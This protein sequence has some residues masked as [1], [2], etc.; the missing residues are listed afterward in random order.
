MSVNLGDTTTEG[1]ENGLSPAQMHVCGPYTAADNGSIDSISVDLHGSNGSP[2]GSVAYRLVV[3]E[4]IAGVVS[5]LVAQTADHTL[6]QDDNGTVTWAPKALA[7]LVSGHFYAIGVE[8]GAQFLAT[9]LN[10]KYTTGG[11]TIYYVNSG[12]TFGTD[13]PSNYPGS[14][15]TIGWQMGKAY[16]TY[17]PGSIV[18]VAL[19][20]TQNQAASLPKTVGRVLVA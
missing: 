8:A 17:T 3:Y 19:T 12:I 18:P 9:V 10:Y 7:S 6:N 15:G 14:P 4:I 11:K 20:A 2:G 16:L 1:S 5:G 13:A